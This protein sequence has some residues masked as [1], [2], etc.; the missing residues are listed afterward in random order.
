MVSE[1]YDRWRENRDWRIPE[2]PAGSVGSGERGNIA[3][4]VQVTADDV[5]P[6]VDR[7][8]AGLLEPHPR[9]RRRGVADW[10]HGSSHRDGEW[11]ANAL[12]FFLNLRRRLDDPAE[13]FSEDAAT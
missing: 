2:S 12:R 8:I 6:M 7:T 5:K 1:D 9:S 10:S 3:S 4:V 13:S 11:R